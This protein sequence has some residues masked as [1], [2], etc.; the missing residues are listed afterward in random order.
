MNI[1]L[2]ISVVFFYVTSSNLCFAQENTIKTAQ[3]ILFSLDACQ[4]Y[5]AK[6]I[7]YMNTQARKALGLLP[8]LDTQN[9]TLI[10]IFHYYLAY[11]YHLLST[12]DSA[13]Y[14][15]NQ[16]NRLLQHRPSITH[17]KPLSVANFMN[18]QG[19]F[20]AE[21][22][23]NYNKAI[24][25][26]TQALSISK[27]YNLKASENSYLNNLGNVYDWLGDYKKAYQYYQQI[28]FR[29]QG[30]SDFLS[31]IGWNT[32]HRKQYSEAT[33]Y[34]ML[35]LAHVKKEEEQNQA[36]F[37]LG[38]CYNKSQQISKSEYFL[39][40]SLHYYQR[41]HIAKHIRVSY[42]FLYQAQNAIMKAK[43]EQALFYVQ[44]GL[45]SIVITFNNPDLLSNPSLSE[46]NLSNESLFE[47]LIQKAI[48]LSQLSKLYPRRYSIDLAVHTYALAIALAEK[49]RKTLDFQGDKLA[50]N[51]QRST[52]FSQ[53]IELGYRWY[54]QKP[55]ID[56]ANV[57]IRMLES[58]KAIVLNDKMANSQLQVPNNALALND[59]IVTKNQEVARLQQ[60]LSQNK[61]THPKKDSLMHLW[62]LS[63]LEISQLNDRLA[64]MLPDK[65]STS[66]TSDISIRELVASIPLQTTYI[67]YII[68]P[69]AQVYVWVLNAHLISI[70]KLVLPATLLQRDLPL[71]VQ[72][73][74]QNPG[75]SA[76]QGTLL[77]RHLYHYL[78]APLAPLLEQSTR[79]LICR[80]GALNFL[81]FEIL[82]TGKRMEDYL[83]KHYAIS[84]QYTT[85]SYVLH[86]GQRAISN[87]KVLDIS[88]FEH[89]ISLPN[90]THLSV[91]SA[92]TP[93]RN[94]TQLRGKGASKAAFLAQYKQYDIIHLQCHSVADTSGNGNAY[95]YFSPNENNYTLGYHEIMNMPFSHCKL[96]LLPT[97]N[98]ANGQFIKHETV[99][100]LC[101]AFYHAGC[102][103]VLAAQWQ[104]QDRASAFIST[105]FYAHLQQGKS[106]D[107]A[108]QQA[109]LAFLTTHKDLNHPYFWASLCLIGNEEAIQSNADIPWLLLGV[110]FL[111]GGIVIMIHQKKPK[112]VATII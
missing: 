105:R 110:V 86:R 84:Y 49:H 34:F 18:L 80:D 33:R 107:L 76:Y 43:L 106:K 95:L 29:K 81:P 73:L 54:S 60:Q 1:F 91:L 30:T 82:E 19:L 15:F 68:S 77:S 11:N 24:L 79:L 38:V 59:T 17:K 13:Q 97:C 23:Y 45:Q 85:L 101:Y 99:Q 41:Q 78:I 21:K 87:A 56:K 12:R 109:K 22:C 31:S 65:S 3:K 47:L 8:H 46:L 108:L 62:H 102:K 67:S 71:L 58:S 88:P 100:S 51:Q 75:F 83:L 57:L 50:F 7:H 72:S 4:T 63:S 9:E 94:A 27:K 89:T 40:C 6:E 93:L 28:D 20:Y 16:A 92:S 35:Q 32:L 61:L 10:F 25:Y 36:Y 70:K 2:K 26:Y 104:A 90:K 42:I 5:D 44:Q 96:L 66:S 98:S 64:S 69:D 55:S 112:K 103:A 14:F 39:N 48:V 52:V 37:N 53:A 74:H 111:I